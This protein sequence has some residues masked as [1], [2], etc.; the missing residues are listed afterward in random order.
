MCK[1][2]TYVITLFLLFSLIAIVGEVSVRN[3]S[4]LMT[5]LQAIISII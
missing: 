3:A 4:L 5:A 2:I 1:L